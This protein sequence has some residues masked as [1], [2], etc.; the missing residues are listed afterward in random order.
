METLT[1][2]SSF[3]TKKDV[4]LVFLIPQRNPS[5]HWQAFWVNLHVGW[6]DGGH[7]NGCVTVHSMRGNPQINPITLF[8]AGLKGTLWSLSSETIQ[9][10]NL[11]KE[12][13][14]FSCNPY[15][16]KSEKEKV[17]PNVG[18]DTQANIGHLKPCVEAWTLDDLHFHLACYLCKNQETLQL[19]VNEQNSGGG[20]SGRGNELKRDGD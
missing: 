20:L 8:K 11:I 13:S 19:K 5:K 17:L 10:I 18:T 1:Y 7:K 12:G 16:R 3:E 9:S 15:W 4:S 14:H 6:C 2:P